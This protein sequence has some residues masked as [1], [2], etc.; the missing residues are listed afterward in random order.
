[1]SLPVS[2]GEVAE[3]MEG[4]DDLC[5]VYLHRDSG[6][7]VMVTEEDAEHVASGDADESLPEW[8]QADLPRVREVLSSEAFVPLPPKSE[9]KEYSV[10]EE[11]CESVEAPAL[12]AEL[13]EAIH[14]RGAF[15][16]FKYAIRAHEIA[17][18]WYQL[19]NKA[20]RVLAADFLTSEAIPFTEEDRI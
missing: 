16:R 14:S 8:Q 6:E 9:I 12:R 3:A 11:F 10:M 15:G 18:D 1:M 17:P 7:L 4:A 19:R 13:L 2:L 5:I 20:V